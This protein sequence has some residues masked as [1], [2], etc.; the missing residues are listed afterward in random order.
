MLKRFIENIPETGEEINPNNKE[1]K[2]IKYL[3]KKLKRDY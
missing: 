2:I 1:K 3:K